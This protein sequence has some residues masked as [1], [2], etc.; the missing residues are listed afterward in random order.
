MKRPF[1]LLSAALLFQLA[2]IAQPVYF[3][4]AQYWQQ[5]IKYMMNVDLDVQTN[6]IRGHQLITY[7]N[8]SPDTL[9]RIFIHLF[10]NAFK[11]N[12]MMD[13]SCRSTE[14]LVIVTDRRGRSFTDFDS[15]FKKRIN[16]M[17][18]GEE[19]YCNISKWR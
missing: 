11:P 8:N 14:N 10:W 18:P 15:R 13:V 6:I 7:T 17:T 9:K 5:H 12:S 2:I 19:G 4:S 3:G 16:E 1:F